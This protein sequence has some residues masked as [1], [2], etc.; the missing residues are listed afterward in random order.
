MDFP[1]SPIPGVSAYEHFRP[2]LYTHDLRY[3]YGSDKGRPRDAWQRVVAGMTPAQQIAALERYGFSGIYVNGAGYQDGGE[4]LL[5][6]YKAAGRGDVI[7][8]PEKDLY[9]VV[10]K[11]SPNPEL[12]PIGPLFADGWYTEQDNPNGQ[13]LNLAGGNAS[14]LLTNPTS[15]PVEKYANFFIASLA[16]RI[17]TIQGDGAYQ[18]WHVDQQRSAKVTNLEL[19]LPPGESRLLFNTN[20]PPTPQQMGPLTFYLVNFELTD[21]PKPEQ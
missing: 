4:A 8:S 7:P 21:S 2:Y 18:S 19:T 15:A 5:A 9:C 13:R 10:L 14:V 3:S 20:A 11:P 12:P 16:P 1:E 17:V 6:Q